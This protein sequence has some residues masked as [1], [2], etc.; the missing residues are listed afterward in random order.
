MQ[1]FQQVQGCENSARYLVFD[2]DTIYVHSNITKGDE[3]WTYDEIQCSYEEFKE[4]QTELLKI[5][6]NETIDE[7]TFSLL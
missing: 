6:E 5:L 4:K 1:T 3:V 7:Y 2:K